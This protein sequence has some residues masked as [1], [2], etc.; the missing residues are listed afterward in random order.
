MDD[1]DRLKSE[2][3]L[4]SEQT[5]PP[6]ARAPQ[7]NE[8]DRVQQS[9]AFGE[10]MQRRRRFLI[11]TVIFYHSFWLLWIVLG[12]FTPALDGQAIGAITWALVYWLGQAVMVLVV[13]QLYVRQAN[14]WDGLVEEAR[15]EANEGRPTA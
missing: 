7:N 9:S 10:L 5:A 13:A 1:N 14:K 8:S 2:E 12:E 15:I 6:H 3:Q 4:A 11:P